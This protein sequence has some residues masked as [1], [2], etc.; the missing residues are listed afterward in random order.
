MMKISKPTHYFLG[1]IFGFSIF[2]LAIPNG[3][4]Q[5]SIVENKWLVSP[6]LHSL[7]LR[8]ILA[9]PICLVGLIFVIWSNIWLLMVGKGGPAEGFGVAI[10]PR[11]EKLVTT[12]PYRYSRNPMVFGAFSFYFSL[13]IAFDSLLGILVISSLVLLLAIPYLKGSEEKRLFNDFGEEYLA[14][15]KKTPMIFPR[16]QKVTY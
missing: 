7:T 8:L 12:G 14:Y 1:Y 4:I 11:T 5:L 6:L 16:W 3:L 13:T 9:I 2:V 10:S 15:K